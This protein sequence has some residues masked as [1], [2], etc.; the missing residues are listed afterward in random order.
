MS[1]WMI[2]LVAAGVLAVG[3]GLYV[4]RRRAER[5]GSPDDVYPLY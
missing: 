4:S 1:W 5:R 2:A 3:A